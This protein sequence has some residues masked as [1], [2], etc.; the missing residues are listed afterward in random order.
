M[1]KRSRWLAIGLVNLALFGG[2]YWT[3]L[4][5][6]DWYIDTLRPA[7]L[8]YDP[9]PF[10]RQQ[11]KPNQHY[12]K[13]GVEFDIGPHRLRGPMPTATKTVDRPRV[14]FMGGSSVFDHLTSVSWPERF[15]QL[16]G[17]ESHN[18]GVPGFS[19]RE[20]VSFLYDKIRYYDP[21]IV[22]F[23]LGWN[24]VKYMKLFKDEIDV[25]R[26]YTFR[27]AFF[28]QYDIFSK[29][30]PVRNWIALKRLFSRAS[31][32]LREN[33]AVSSDTGN[34]HSDPP[35]SEIEWA[36]TKGIQFWESNVTNFVR[37]AKQFN[38][39]AILSAQTTLV[40][41][42]MPEK[43]K[44]VVAYEFV[45]LTHQE[46]VSVNQA[47][48]ECLRRVAQREG[49]PFVDPRGRLNGKRQ[50]FGDHIHVSP[51]GSEVLAQEMARLLGPL[52][53]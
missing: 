38:I 50:F 36:K 34:A 13:G 24:D 2:G 10:Y 28:A 31:T 49:V 3:F 47:M 14:F 48:A 22:V 11:L 40:V 32:R 16:V 12:R 44:K 5:V 1:T 20:T 25:D 7:M 6:T 4:E 21:D 35:G 19:S 27:S 8:M 43:D 15:G 46:L 53:R 37:M 29:P 23:Y 52:I 26:H 39:R 9:H 30:R 45:N 33:R 41:D 17:A 51:E 18:A 42:S